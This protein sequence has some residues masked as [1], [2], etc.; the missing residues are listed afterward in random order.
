MRHHTEI[1][2]PSKHKN[3]SPY[4]VPVFARSLA[5]CS[6]LAFKME[7]AFLYSFFLLFVPFTVSLT[8]IQQ[9]KVARKGVVTAVAER[10][11]VKLKLKGG[12]CYLQ[13]AKPSSGLLVRQG[14]KLQ[15]LLARQRY[16]S[17]LPPLC[18]VPSV[19]FLPRLH[20]CIT[21]GYR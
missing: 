7:G 21:P 2:K 14:T 19:R 12:V 9:C 3:R 13:S 5:R 15:K 4:R 1:I 18:R 16:R 17:A 6:R 10:G 11:T 8:H 20:T